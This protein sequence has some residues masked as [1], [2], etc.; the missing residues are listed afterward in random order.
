MRCGVVIV[1]VF[2]SVAWSGGLRY[3]V[4]PEAGVA[5]YAT[6]ALGYTPGTHILTMLPDDDQ[7]AVAFNLDFSPGIGKKYAPSFRENLKKLTPRDTQL[8]LE[9]I[10]LSTA[11]TLL[12]RTLKVRGGT[13][14]GSQVKLSTGLT[15]DVQLETFGEEFS[16]AVLGEP[17]GL[18]SGLGE[19]VKAGASAKIRLLD[20][21][22]GDSL[23]LSIKGAFTQ[24]VDEIFGTSAGELIV[25]YRPISQLALIFNPKVWNCWIGYISGHW[26]GS[27]LSDLAGLSSYR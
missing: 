23:S 12:A 21:V 10:T 11:D 20:Q 19:G 3:L 2:K 18:V 5:V 24:D 14:A 25:Q 27:K 13:G 6:N 7:V 4:S 9:G 8:L 26:I 16:D 1:S 22:Q 15:R 17:G